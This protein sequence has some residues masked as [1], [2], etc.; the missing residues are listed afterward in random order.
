MVQ[1]LEQLNQGFFIEQYLARRQLP[2]QAHYRPQ[3][4]S[5]SLQAEVERWIQ[6]LIDDPDLEEAEEAINAAMPALPIY[7]NA[8]EMPGQYTGAAAPAAQTFGPWLPSYEDAADAAMPALP[9]SSIA[10]EEDR[11]EAPTQEVSPIAEKAQ[12]KSSLWKSISNIVFYAALAAVVLG[13]V[14]IGNNNNG[15]SRFLS[16]QYSAVLSPSMQSMIPQGSLV[17]TKKV[18]S[19]QI[20]AGDVITF[21]RSDEESVTH[22]V[23]D[24]VP[25]FDGRGSLGFRTKGTDN[26]DP[27]PDIVG[28]ANVIGVVKVHV[29]GLGFTMRYISENI[30][31]VF[32]AFIFIILISIAMRVLLG[33]SKKTQVQQP[34]EGCGHKKYRRDEKRPTESTN[35]QSKK[36]TTMAA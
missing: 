22:Q 21:L 24:V 18:P 2:Q 8:W 16:Y 29:N 25:D 20:K 26:M 30:K 15:S 11:S 19:A 34:D 17:I 32:L 3:P 6:D 14:I 31:Y 7:A 27:D 5:P 13:A 23:I 28:A 1:T 12:A 9:K 35:Y 36:Q 10:P 4:P 33:D